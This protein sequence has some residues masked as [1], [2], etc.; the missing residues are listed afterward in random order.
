LP[1]LVV[2]SVTITRYAVDYNSTVTIDVSTTTTDRVKLT[3][4]WAFAAQTYVATREL[5]GATGYVVDITMSTPRF[6][7]RPGGGS[8]T[9]TSDPAA[10]NGKVSET[11]AV[12]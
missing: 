5:A 6:C 4:K 1:E 7:E 2:T 11:F 12:C 8:L 10:L 3:V 9:V